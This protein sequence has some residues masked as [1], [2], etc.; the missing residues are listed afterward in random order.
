MNISVMRWAALAGAFGGVIVSSHLCSCD[1]PSNSQLVT[2]DSATAASV[3]VRTVPSASVAPVTC[4]RV[5]CPKDHS[6]LSVSVIIPEDN[7]HCAVECCEG[8]ACGEHMLPLVNKKTGK[9]E[10]YYDTREHKFV[11]V[12]G[13]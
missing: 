11:E 7:E 1:A 3:Q 10:R 2:V 8:A 13:P 5:T 9:T 12:G 4:P 6:F